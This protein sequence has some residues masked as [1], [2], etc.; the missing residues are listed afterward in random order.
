VRQNAPQVTVKLKSRLL[1]GLVVVLFLVQLVTPDRA[2]S[3]LLL[4]LGGVLGLSYV[5][6]RQMATKLTISREQ[7]YGW[8]HVGDLLEERFS[9]CNESLL[10]SLW[11]EINDQSDLPGYSARSVRSADA[12]QTVDWRTE[13]ICRQRGLFTLG[14]WQARLSDPLGLFQVIFDYPDSQ[15]VLVY[16]PIVHLPSLRLPRGAA[17]GMG[18]ISRHAQEVTTNAAGVRAYAPGDSTN[19]IHWRTTART[20]DLMVKTFDLEP[21]GDLWIVLDLDAAVQA[22]EAAESTEEYGVILAASLSSRTLHQN[23]AVGLVAYGTIGARNGQ[24]AEP[25][26]TIVLPQKGTA[27]QWRILQALTTVHAGGNWPLER[28]LSE[29]DRNLGRGTTL[30][31]I[32]PSC[33]PA[34]VAGLLPPM[35]RGVAPS[36]VLLDPV[37]FGGS[38]DADALI[39]LLADLGVPADRIVQGMPFTPIAQHK[40][41]GRPEYRVLTATGRVIV[42]DQ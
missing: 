3:F 8:V 39:R 4:G 21:S 30:A 37:S 40:R 5:W 33:D 23:R 35:R 22:G 36:V 26:P 1:P 42:V 13:G 31:V 16:P 41:I 20:E 19:R 17:T 2:W 6:A 15:S 7:H 14:P 9:L 25:L 28:V 10:P 18:R 12:Q 27:H 24:S 11:V 34:W 38:G 29:M 32:T